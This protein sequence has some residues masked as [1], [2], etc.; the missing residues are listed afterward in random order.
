[1]MNTSNRMMMDDERNNNMIMNNNNIS[2]SSRGVGMEDRTNGGEDGLIKTNVVGGGGGGG[3]VQVLSSL[4]MDYIHA[5]SFDHY[6]RRLATCGGDQTVK[7]WDLNDNGEWQLCSST[8]HAKKNPVTCLS[9]AHP[10]FG[11]LLATC[12]ASTTTVWEERSTQ[13]ISKVSF[14]TSGVD[15]CVEFAP[16]HLGLKLAT[17]SADGTVRIYEAIDIMNLN[18]WPR[19]SFFTTDHHSNTTTT[20]ST[21]NTSTHNDNNTHHHGD[22]AN[23]RR[24]NTSVL[25]VTS[26]SWCTGKI[27]PPTLVVASNVSVGVYVYSDASRNWSRLVTLPTNN[28]GALDVSWAPNIGRTYHDIAICT[29]QGTLQVHTLSRGGTIKHQSHQELSS[30]SSSTDV[31]K[32]AWNVTGTVLA[33]SGDNGVVQLWKCNFHKQWKCVSQIKGSTL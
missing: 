3:G 9:W 28:M 17:G 29:T 30:S 27:E 10:E 13:W 14:V 31:W 26:L 4:H 25:G 7:V 23:H 6:G 5:M 12:G 16:R 20:T 33:S 15:R 24:P 11:A 18:H 22:E 19:H 1:M 32:C 21:T 2:S 8:E